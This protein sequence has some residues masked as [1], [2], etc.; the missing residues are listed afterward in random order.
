MLRELGAVVSIDF[1]LAFCPSFAGTRSRITVRETFLLGP[2]QGG[3]V[4]EDALALI[5]IPR[6]T[7]PH[8]DRSQ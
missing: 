6:P 3:F 8:H 2:S 7:E 4:N 1:G 5:A